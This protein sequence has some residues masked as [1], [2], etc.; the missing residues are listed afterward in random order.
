MKIPKAAT[1]LVKYGQKY[2]CGNF[3]CF[4]TNI[5]SLKG[6]PTTVIGSFNCT[7]TK[8]SSLEG[9]PSTVTGDFDCSYND[10]TSLHNIHKLLSSVGGNLVLPNIKQC[11]LG[12]LFVKVGKFEFVNNPTLT[13]ILNK[14]KN[15]PHLLVQCKIDL[16]NA[17]LVE[18]AKL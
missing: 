13:D 3:D 2:Q 15:Q 5:T 7:L 18:C 4:A 16:I 6:C 11:V 12:L 1:S 14:Y 10:I 9:C 8:I 17:G